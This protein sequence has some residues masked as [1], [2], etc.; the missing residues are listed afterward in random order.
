[1]SNRLAKPAI[2]KNAT[3]G[4]A[5]FGDE[6]CS[7]NSLLCECTH[8]QSHRGYLLFEKKDHASVAPF[9]CIST[10]INSCSHNIFLVHTHAYIADRIIVKVVKLTVCLIASSLLLTQC[11]DEAQSACDVEV[12]E[13]SK[14]G[15]WYVW[16]SG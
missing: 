10:W 5:A 7:R 1:M 13:K 15:L 12:A 3:V 8:N 4:Q 6:C 16:S 9:L 14:D 2:Y 11:Y